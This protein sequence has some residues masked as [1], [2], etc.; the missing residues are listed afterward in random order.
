MARIA[1][2]K[3]IERELDRIAH[4]LEKIGSLATAEKVYDARRSVL[5][6]MR[7]K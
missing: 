4:K 2:L 7:S 3:S 6:A 1:I 5:R